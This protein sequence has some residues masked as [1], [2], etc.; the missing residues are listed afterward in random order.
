MDTGATMV[1][2]NRSTARRI[3]ISLS[4]GDFRHEVQTAN[5]ATKA[6]AAVIDRIQIGRITLQNVEAAVLDDAALDGALV[7][8]SFLKRLSKF[9]MQDGALLMQ[10]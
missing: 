4:P 6:A 5:G 2:I 1:A 3:G 8:M 10:Q 7:G 9:E